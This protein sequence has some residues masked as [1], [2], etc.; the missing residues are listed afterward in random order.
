[1]GDGGMGTALYVQVIKFRKV[2]SEPP[3]ESPIFGGLP[4]LGT[5]LPSKSPRMGDS[6]G[7]KDW[8]VANLDLLCTP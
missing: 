4:N 1:M 7:E 6:G 8:S 2:P 3:P 5:Y